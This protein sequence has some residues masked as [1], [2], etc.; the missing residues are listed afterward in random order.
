M[1]RRIALFGATST[2]CRQVALQLVQ[3]G[4]RVCLAARNLAELSRVASDLTIRNRPAI[5]LEKR[6]DTGER[7][8]HQALAEEICESLGGLDIVIVG[9][10]EL[11]D[12]AAARS[13]IAAIERIVH[14]NFTG[15]ATLLAPIADHMERQG[16]G[17]IV[18]LSSVAGDRGRQSNYVYGSAKSGMSIYL[19]GLENRVHRAGVCVRTIKLGFVDTKMV[20][21]R[22]GMFLVATPE[23][24]AGA[25]VAKMRSGSGVAYIPWFWRY[26]MLAIVHIPSILFKRMAL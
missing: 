24:A 5:V 9:T 18:V 19:E 16:S 8:A 23:D 1:A 21:G 13:S 22:S 17:R 2:I 11:G 6:F 4:D 26:I 20:F 15:I 3:P 25:I 12:Q 7:S 10:G 14:S